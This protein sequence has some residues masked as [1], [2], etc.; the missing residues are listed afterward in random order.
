V[1]LSYG[2]TVPAAELIGRRILDVVRDSAG[3]SVVLHEAS[4]ASYIIHSERLA[5]PVSI[6]SFFL[7][8][9]CASDGP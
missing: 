5:T 7:S 8:F 3:N 6:P 9:F 2:A 4:L 1:K